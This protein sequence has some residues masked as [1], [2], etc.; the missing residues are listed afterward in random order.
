MFGI[1]TATTPSWT[2]SNGV[3]AK[4][5]DALGD[6][7]IHIAAGGKLILTGSEGHNV[8]VFDAFQLGDLTVSRSGSTVIFSDNATPTSHQIASIAVTSFAP[9]QTI[10]FSDGTHVELTLT[11]TTLALVNSSNVST[12]IL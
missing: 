3:V 8:V 6:Q 9:S 1:Q 11:G 5:I 12:P 4:V 2:V 7:V 10:G